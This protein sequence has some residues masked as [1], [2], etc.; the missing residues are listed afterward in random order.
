MLEA[1]VT[2][3]SSNRAATEA[4]VAIDTNNPLSLSVDDDKNPV[5]PNNVV[6]YTLA[7]GNRALTSSITGTTLKF[8]IP[9]GTTFVSATGGGTLSSGKVQ[10]TLGSLAATQS[11]RQQVV[12]LLN[13]GLAAG[14]VLAVNAATISGLNSSLVTES[15][16]ATAVSRVATNPPFVIGVELN[17]DPVR[18][19]S[20][21]SHS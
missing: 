13:N 11:D 8:P 20:R 17:P 18:P 19:A 15:A 6:T 5:A 7:Y 16:S 1:L 9:V 4:T 2:D 12:V 14:T 21:R 10:W 3:D